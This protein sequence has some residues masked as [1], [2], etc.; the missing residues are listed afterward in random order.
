[1]LPLYRQ[2]RQAEETTTSLK[3]IAE[4]LRMGSWIYVSNLRNKIW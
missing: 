2:A 4:R 1:M 3:R